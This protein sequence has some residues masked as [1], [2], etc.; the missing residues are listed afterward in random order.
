[1]RKPKLCGRRRR[2]KEGSFQ[3]RGGRGNKIYCYQRRHVLF[4]H[5]ELPSK[6]FLFP[7][8]PPDLHVHPLHVPHQLVLSPN[9]MDLHFPVAHQGYSKVKG[10]GVGRMPGSF[11][12]RDLRTHSKH[13]EHF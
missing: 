10:W 13:S 3:N 2:V 1:M 8:F 11:F 12:W 4:G 6:R 7:P 5:G 9:F